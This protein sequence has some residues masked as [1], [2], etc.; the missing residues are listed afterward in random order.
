M[1]VRYVPCVPI[2]S[3]FSGILCQKILLFFRHMSFTLILSAHFAN[4]LFQLPFVG[5]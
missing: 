4:D 5:V 2:M 1:H 3:S